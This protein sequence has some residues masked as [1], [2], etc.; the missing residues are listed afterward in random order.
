MSMASSGPPDDDLIGGPLPRST[1]AAP[2]PGRE[3]LDHLG[4]QKFEF[5]AKIASSFFPEARHFPARHFP[6]GHFPTRHF[7]AGHFPIGHFLALNWQPWP[8]SLQP[9][10]TGSRSE[11]KWA[12]SAQ[13]QRVSKNPRKFILN[14]IECMQRSLFLGRC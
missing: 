7:P 14:R 8:C 9:L 2:T 10:T 12:R 3:G 4:P 5:P 1:P 13:F 11:L 6:A